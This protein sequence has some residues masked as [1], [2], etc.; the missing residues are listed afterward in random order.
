MA[1]CLLSSAYFN[2]YTFLFDIGSK[3]GKKDKKT[4]KIKRSKDE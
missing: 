1:S 4:K 2:K 3:G